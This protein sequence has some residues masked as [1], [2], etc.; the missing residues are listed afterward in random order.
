MRLL[1]FGSTGPSGTILCHQALRRGHALVLYTRSPT[2]LPSS[3]T[4]SP[5]VQIVKGELADVGLFTSC[6]RDTE[7]VLSTLGPVPHQESS[8]LFTTFYAHLAGAMQATGVKRL[9]FTSPP[10]IRNDKDGEKPVLWR[11]LS[12][13]AYAW[14]R[15]WT[16]GYE[17]VESTASFFKGRPDGIEWTMLRVPVL[18]A[19]SAETPAPVHAG[20]Y[21]DKEMTS[22]LKREDLARC[23]LD[24]LDEPKWMYQMPLL[25]SL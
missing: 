2:K 6:L 8:S 15:G 16:K 24:E 12:G 22:R 19:G 7:A 20:Y 25:C 3:L 14:L 5:H 23:I 18:V 10:N 21:G 9:I 1:I 13:P 17:D 11:V 4:S